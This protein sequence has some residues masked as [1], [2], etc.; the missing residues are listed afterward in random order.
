MDIV[1]SS[2]ESVGTGPAAV[3]G[4]VAHPLPNAGKPE[5]T[6]Q[7]E[8]KAAIRDPAELCRR[9]GLTDPLIPGPGA[10]AHRRFRTFV[11]EPYLARIRPGTPD[12][13]L[14]LQVLPAGEEVVEA[15]SFVADPVGDQVAMR[16]PGLIQKY[17]G[18]ALLIAAGACAIHCRYCFRREFPYEAAPRSASQFREALD[19]I[20]NDTSVTEL[21][22][23][24]GDPLM[25]T[26][27]VLAR[28]LEDASGIAHLR[29]LRIHTRLPVVIPQRVTDALLETLEGI[30]QAVV[31]VLHINHPREID[32]D[33]ASAASRLA[34]AGALLLNQSVLLRRVNDDAETLVELSRRLID[35]RCLPYYLHQLDRVQGAAHFE[36]PVARGRELVRQMRK[37]LPGYAV[38]RFVREVPGKPSKVWLT[39]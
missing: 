38:P 17:Q 39:G 12:D 34:G 35:I 28:L 18:R 11:P 7:Q 13:P 36:V 14:L 8:V 25:L 15:P 26:D 4:A 10:E 9:L 22:L 3:S 27:D 33:V 32:E 20:C 1:S 6:W 16:H 5:P 29:R 23:S 37:A 21:I 2:P 19:V 24:G 30:H 31:V